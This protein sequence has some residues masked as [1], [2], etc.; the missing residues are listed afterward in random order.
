MKVK[1]LLIMFITKKILTHYTI[2]QAVVTHFMNTY[3][4][5][6]RYELDIEIDMTSRV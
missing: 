1:L 3:F 6:I 4:L 2:A 5:D